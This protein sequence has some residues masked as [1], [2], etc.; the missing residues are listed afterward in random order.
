M[1]LIL[2]YQEDFK[3]S[4][5]IWFLRLFTFTVFSIKPVNADMVMLHSF[6]S[7]TVK[8]GDVILT[9]L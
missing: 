5:N 7:T 4:K 6:F 3:F 8:N 1:I 9:G 2:N